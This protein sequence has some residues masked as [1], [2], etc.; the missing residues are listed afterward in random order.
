MT[1]LIALVL[2]SSFQFFLVLLLVLRNGNSGVQPHFASKLCWLYYCQ[3]LS[4]THGWIPLG[5][6]TTP[7]TPFCSNIGKNRLILGRQEKKVVIKLGILANSKLWFSY[8]A[9]SRFVLFVSDRFFFFQ[10]FTAN[11]DMP[12]IWLMQSISGPMLAKTFFGQNY[13]KKRFVEFSS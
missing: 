10:F 13:D 5:P 8:S 4:F 9:L 11:H 1:I 6:V 12:L 3:P 7:R 2:L